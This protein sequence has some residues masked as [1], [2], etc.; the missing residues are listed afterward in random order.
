MGL[1]KRLFGKKDAPEIKEQKTSEEMRE[2]PGLIQV[3]DEYGRE[4]FIDKT[5]WRNDVLPGNLKNAW[6]NQDELYNVIVSALNDEFYKDILTASEHLYKI[7]SNTERGTCIYAIALMKNGKLQKAKKILLSTIKEH[8]ESG[9]LFTNLAKVY[10]EKGDQALTERT[11]WQGLEVDPNQDNAIEWWAAIHQEKS[12]EIGYITALEKSAAIKGSWRSQLWLAR[13]ALNRKNSEKA[14]GYY[15]H[16]TKSITPLPTDAAM[17]ISGDLGNAGRLNDIITI[18]G[19]VFEV[20]IHGLMVGNNL[21]KAHVDL[22]QYNKAQEIIDQLYS[23]NRPDWKS[24]LQYWENEINEHSNKY[25]APVDE[26]EL[27]VTSLSLGWPVWSHKLSNHEL[28]LPVKEKNTVH[29]AFISSSC[30]YPSTQQTSHTQKTDTEGAISRSIPLFLAEQTHMLTTA[31]T[32]MFIPVIANN[33]SFIVSGEPW[34][35]E[36]LVSMANECDYIVNS[37]LDANDKIWNFKVTLMNAKTGNVLETLNQ[38]IDPQD[39]SSDIQQLATKFVSKMIEVYSV[40]KSIPP[41][42][43]QIPKA[44]EFNAYIDS[45]SQTLALTVATSP[46]GTP[47]AIY[48]EHSI[49]DC[50]L[51]L[52]LENPQSDIAQLLF[53]G[54]LAKNKSYGSEIYLEY[55]RKA[56]KLV[57]DQPLSGIA[58]KVVRDTIEA[59]Y[60]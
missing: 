7:D 16:I 4:M 46:D 26:N 15:T 6:D 44:R 34:S 29:V 30:R 38:K 40:Y 1:L 58:A 53:I 45:L 8:G 21:I 48:G 31:T 56:N 17:Q 52:S 49:I 18:V 33:G 54:A 25:S 22:K 59:L 28:L 2:D 19:N 47:S 5:T 41:I 35:T 43:Y 36:A 10:A 55:K 14:L 57:V 11:L 50:L 27:K 13:E 9:V 12:G 23:Q 37:H 20:E 39:P 32:S 3:Y 60:K 24:H 51:T 42:N